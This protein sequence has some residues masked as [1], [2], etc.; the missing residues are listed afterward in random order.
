MEAAE[1]LLGVL[2]HGAPSD[3]SAALEGL[4]K[5]RGARFIELA[6]SAMHTTTPEVQNVLRDVLRSR[7]I[8]A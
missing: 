2:E 7:G 8:A 4:K 6:R 5:S 1:F 3:R